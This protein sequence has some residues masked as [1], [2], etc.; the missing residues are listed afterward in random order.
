MTLTTPLLT[1]WA[2]LARRLRPDEADH[3]AALSGVAFDP[4]I[5]ARCWANT[6]GAVWCLVGADGRPIVAGGFE[7]VRPGVVHAWMVGTPEAWTAHWHA[8]TRACRRLLRATLATDVHRVE[9]TTLHRRVAACAW[10]AKA[11]RLR[12]EALHHAAACD[13]SD[14]VTYA[15][16]RSDP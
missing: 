14:T 11:L 12:F 10:Y 9:V 2:Y 8:I 15:I 16:T 6:P 3:F 5:A 7:P 13:G 4:E 1:D